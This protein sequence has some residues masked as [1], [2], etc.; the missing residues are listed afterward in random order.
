MRGIFIGALVISQIV[1]ALSSSDVWYCGD[2]PGLLCTQVISS[3]LCNARYFTAYSVHNFNPSKILGGATPG[4]ELAER[5][6]RN[7]MANTDTNKDGL[8]SREEAELAK[9][10][11]GVFN[12]IA[13]GDEYISEDDLY[14]HFGCI[15][16]E[17]MVEPNSP[18]TPHTN[19]H[20]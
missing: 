8:I 2:L 19:K 6:I 14:V 20:G 3:F 18:S 10:T 7:L 16:N 9:V 17:V 11:T 5:S 13:R 1:A 12:M 15:S 4:L